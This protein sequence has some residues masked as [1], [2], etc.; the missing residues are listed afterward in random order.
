[1]R[2]DNCELSFV[3]V[4]MQQMENNCHIHPVLGRKKTKKKELRMPCA[5]EKI[6]IKIET[7]KK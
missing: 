1:M 4:V 5:K 7:R 2:F 3:V 6:K